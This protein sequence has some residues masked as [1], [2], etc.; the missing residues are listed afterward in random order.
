MRLLKTD[1]FRSF[2]VGF[3]LGAIGVFATLGGWAGE[4][5]GHSMV[6]QAIAAPVR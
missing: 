1:L 4:T 6:P 5:V 3:V 2:A